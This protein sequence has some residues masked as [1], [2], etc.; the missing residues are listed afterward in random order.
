MTARG[1]KQSNVPEI[2]FWLLCKGDTRVRFA[3]SSEQAGLKLGLQALEMRSS[4]QV[5]AL[6][7]M[8]CYGSETSGCVLE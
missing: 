6:A 7:K 4:G 2:M 8:L 1:R 3:G 5:D